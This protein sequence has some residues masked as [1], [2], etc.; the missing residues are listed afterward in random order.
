MKHVSD[1]RAR[2]SCIMDVINLNF[3]FGSSQS[4]GKFVEEFAKMKIPHYKLVQEGELYYL[5]KD[6]NYEAVK[7]NGDDFGC[8][9]FKCEHIIDVTDV[10]YSRDFDE[11]ASQPS[12]LSSI[13]G[14]VLGTDGTGKTSPNPLL[15]LLSAPMST[16]K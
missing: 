1:S 5:A 6:K 11:I 15:S 10:I 16:F 4:H 2:T 13:S 14:S 12:D 7:E 8:T 3:V 9:K